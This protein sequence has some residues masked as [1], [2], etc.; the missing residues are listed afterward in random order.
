LLT[1]SGLQEAGKPA[2]RFQ[3]EF[4]AEIEPVKQ[5]YIER[6]FQP[7]ILFRDVRDFLRLEKTT[8]TTAYGAE[9]DIPSKVDIL[10][11]GF[12]CK[13]LSRLNNSG[14]TLKDEGESGDTWLA[15]YTYAKRFRPGVVLLENVKATRST[16]DDLV[17]EWDKI[18]YTAGWIYRDTKTYYLPQTRERMYMI[19]VERFQLG[20]NAEEAVDGW[21]STIQKLQRQ[22][23]SPYECFITDS[24]Q[25]PGTYT[26]PLSEVDWPL[27]KLRYDHIRSREKLGNLSPV[28][29]SSGSGTVKY[30][31]S[32]SRNWGTDMCYLDHRTVLAYSTTNHFRP[33]FGMLLILHTCKSPRMALTRYTRWAFGM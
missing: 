20:T 25:E 26:T 13:D 32:N 7:K 14:K 18:G 16:C 10:I 3:H 24:L 23:S 27:C 33:E 30:V 15:I 9:V 31:R 6:N 4:C 22:C 17:A 19:A 29:L 1:K 12:V 8:A 21:K 5:A 28:T 2:I 11:A